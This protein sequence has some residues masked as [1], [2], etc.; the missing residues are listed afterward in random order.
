MAPNPHPYRR[1]AYPQVIRHCLFRCINQNCQVSVANNNED[2]KNNEHLCH[3]NR[4]LA[5]CLNMFCDEG[6]PMGSQLSDMS[7]KHDS[8]F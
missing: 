6:L 5:A 4:T 1:E 8:S 3:W 2:D 7:N